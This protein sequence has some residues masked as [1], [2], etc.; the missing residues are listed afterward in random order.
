[1]A[2]A[3]D[4]KGRRVSFITGC[5]ACG[6][7]FSNPPR[8]REELETYYSTEGPWAAS[9]EER[10]RKTAAE[11]RRRLTHDT[12]PQ[13]TKRRGARETLLDALAQ[14][15]PVHAPPRGA[16]VLDFGCG[17]GL[18]LDRL[19]D[20]GWETYGIEPSSSLSFLR[21]RRLEAP[22][23]DGS[24]DFVLLHHVLEHVAEPL[25]LLRQLA[26][27]L[28]EGGVLFISVPRLDTLPVHHDRRYCLNGRTHVVCF[29]EACLQS[30]LAR[31]H[32]ALTA[33]LD[34]R[35]DALTDGKPLRLRLVATRTAAPPDLPAAPLG[36]ALK[37]LRDDARTNGLASRLLKVLPLRLLAAMADRARE[38]SR[39][40]H[41]TR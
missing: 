3:R 24:F 19:Q 35:L 11:H 1:M 4:A 17:N 26:G 23:Q 21:H 7:L 28:R 9:H 38:R 41:A 5:E 15:V 39:P 6:L 32:L 20:W 10:T 25:G 8:T 14:Y 27:S 2:I 30:L 18:F 12:P 16:R 37:A 36:P 33:R 13:P 40:S 31:A 29:S 34:D 22:P